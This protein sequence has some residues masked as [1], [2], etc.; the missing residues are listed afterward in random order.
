MVPLMTSP[1]LVELMTPAQVPPRSKLP[2]LAPVTGSMVPL[3]EIGM[4]PQKPVV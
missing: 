4:E 1:S 2:V 3:P